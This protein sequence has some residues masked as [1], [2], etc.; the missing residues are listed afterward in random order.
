M[1]RSQYEAK[2]YLDKVRTLSKDVER[3]KL[4]V[5]EYESYVLSVKAM[6]FKE[7]V[8]TGKYKKNV[9]EEKMVK[10]MDKKRGLEELEKK[11]N[12][13]K[14]EIKCMLD[15]IKDK[16]IKALLINRYI[17]LMSWEEISEKMEYKK[18]WIMNLHMEGLDKVSN[19]IN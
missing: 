2:V 18:R 4:K 16:N 12:D 7:K 17:H 11:L 5:E 8:D 3:E 19:L 15:S 13:T 1:T 9:F 10:L 14:N 6:A